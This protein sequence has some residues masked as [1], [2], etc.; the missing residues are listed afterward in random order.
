MRLR[1]VYR[2]LGRKVGLFFEFRFHVISLLFR[3][4]LTSLPEL[5][6]LALSYRNAPSNP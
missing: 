1:G 3:F 5:M 2:L 6:P 4:P